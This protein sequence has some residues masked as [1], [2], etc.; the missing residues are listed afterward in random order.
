MPLLARMLIRLAGFAL[1]LGILAADAQPTLWAAPPAAER[2]VYLARDL[3]DENLIVLGAALAAWREDSVLLLDSAKVSPYLKTFLAAYKPTRV[4]PVG[5]DVA[6]V[7]ELE[8][9][10]DI[11]T[12]TPVNWAHGPPLALWRSLFNRAEDVVVCPAH[13]RGTLLQAACLAGALR[14]PLYVVHGT[15]SEGDKL[16]QRLAAWHTRRVHLIGKADKLAGRLHGVE[17]LPLT[18]ENAVATAYQ[19]LLARQGRI[20]NVVLSNPADIGEDLGGT[21]ALAPWIAVNRHAALLLTN[22]EGTNVAEVIDRAGGARRCGISTPCCS[23]PTCAPSPCGSGPI[24]S[25]ATR[26]RTSRWSR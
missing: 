6:S 4:V 9:R 25:P 18:G 26:I 22:P 14:A 5:G 8:R 19:K 17:Q 3:P 12:S 11:K 16:A 20:E 24:R 21:S 2:T 13:P 7:K 15:A 23:S 1:A 10:L